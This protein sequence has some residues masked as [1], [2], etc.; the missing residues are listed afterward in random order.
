MK[1]NI[2]FKSYT[3]LVLFKRMHV[4]YVCIYIYVQFYK[5][6]KLKFILYDQLVNA[7]K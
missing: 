7:F 3:S 1:V 2:I 5:T 6:N 4:Y